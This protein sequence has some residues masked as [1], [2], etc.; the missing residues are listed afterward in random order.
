MTRFYRAAIFVDVLSTEPLSGDIDLAGLHRLI[1]DGPMS[2]KIVKG[3]SEEIT[4]PHMIRLCESHS[5]D[6]WFF[7]IGV[8]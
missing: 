4:E 2:G 3:E 1:T 8:E 7:G 5:T 6:P